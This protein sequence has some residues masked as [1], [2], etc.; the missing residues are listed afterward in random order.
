MYV[1][2]V[3][4]HTCNEQV[5]VYKGWCTCVVVVQVIMLLY[6]CC[7]QVLCTGVRVQ[8]YNVG[9]QVTMLVCRLQYW[10]TDYNGGVQVT[11]LLYMYCVQV[12]CTGAGVQVLCT[13]VVYR[14]SCT[15][16]RVQVY[17]GG[18]QVTM[19]VNMLQC[20]YTASNGGV[21][22]TMVMYMLQYW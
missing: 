12:L 9:L 15:G 2:H 16:V 14:C 6:R 19:L 7:V 11:M 8:V 5:L 4:L 3:C 21:Q 20:W 13:G 10:Y 1:V 17:D 22:V 18:V